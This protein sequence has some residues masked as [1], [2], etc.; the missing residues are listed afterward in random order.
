MTYLDSLNLM[1]SLNQSQDSSASN[2]YETDLKFDSGYFG[3]SLV[4]E[5][6]RVFVAPPTKPKGANHVVHMSSSPFI[7]AFVSNQS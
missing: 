4:Q 6:T 2:F 1:H 3:A 5:P 7:F